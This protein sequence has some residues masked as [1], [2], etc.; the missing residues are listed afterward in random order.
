LSQS[1]SA[2]G[3]VVAR[4]R[5]HARV[6]ALVTALVVAS[7]TLARASDVPVRPLEGP[8]V[9]AR[10][11]SD[12]QYLWNAS[13]YVAHLLADK[14]GDAPG[15]HALEATALSA[16]AERTR[17][18]DA[19]TVRIKVVYAKTG[20]V[21]PVYGTAT[22]TGMENVVTLSASRTELVKHADQWARDVSAGRVPPGLDVR[23]TGTLP[24]VR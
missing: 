9:L 12:A 10:A 23:V 1:S 4:L 5:V 16:L 6:A 21:S 8:V 3:Y 14:L 13:T 22:F 11:G 7:A 18:S 15:L 17:A 20:A 2:A 19:A 24:P